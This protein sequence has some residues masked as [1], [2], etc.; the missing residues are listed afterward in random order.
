MKVTLKAEITKISAEKD[1]LDDKLKDK[2]DE[3]QL[4][5]EIEFG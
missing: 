4:K 1:Q 2:N 5:N 3:I